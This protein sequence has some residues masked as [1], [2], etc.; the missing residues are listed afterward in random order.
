MA[1]PT[2]LAHAWLVSH[3]FGQV[4][5]SIIGFKKLKKYVQ[6]DRE[7]GAVFVASVKLPVTEMVLKSSG[8]TFY[9]SWSTSYAWAWKEALKYFVP[10]Q[11]CLTTRQHFQLFLGRHSNKLVLWVVSDTL[12]RTG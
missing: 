3:T 5:V 4:N 11:G 7:A 1:S 12:S 10:W 6:S 2:Y 9:I 8:F